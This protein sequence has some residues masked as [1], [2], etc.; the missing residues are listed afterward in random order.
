[1]ANLNA[2]LQ[3]GE[4]LILDGATGTE[5]QRRGA[6]M[7]GIAW[8]AA[9]LQTHPDL[10]RALH[11]DYIHAGADV[12]ITNSFSTHRHLLEPAGLADSFHE[13]NRRAVALARE[14]RE[15][16]AADRPVYIA[17][18][19]STFLGELDPVNWPPPEQ[20]S[21][22]YREQ[23]EVLAE[24]GA[25]LF[26]L[27]M[28]R[29]LERGPRAAEAA[30][31]TG[32]PAWAAFTCRVTDDSRVVLIRDDHSPVIQDE[33]A[34]AV[35]VFAGLGVAG[36]SVMH[37]EVSETAAALRVLREHWPG[38]VGAYA[39]S[40]HFVMPNWQFESV[41]SPEAYAE[42]A[43]GWVAGGVQL[44]GGCCGIGPDHIRTLR[45]QL[46]QGQEEVNLS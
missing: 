11:E 14:A 28:M 41:I 38:P 34:T 31:A 43:A 3:Q 10:V 20:V 45:R 6:P 12:I 46:L 40:G 26:F 33:L 22:W 1:M 18:S 35:E 39:H 42:A 2:R 16:A 32:L 36:C 24:A 23:A 15:R 27:E 37:S 25:D 13:L 5:L 9:A 19:I 30:I 7:H 4:L 44:V 8:S 29:D 17:A 21:A